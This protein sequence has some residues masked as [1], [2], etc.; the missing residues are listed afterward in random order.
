MKKAK[1][2]S[3]TRW[4][5]TELEVTCVGEKHEVWVSIQA[6]GPTIEMAY[7]ACLAN[8][9]NY[10]RLPENCTIS[11]YQHVLQRAELHWTSRHSLCD[12]GWVEGTAILLGFKSS[13][14]PMQKSK[15]RKALLAE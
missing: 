4:G 13:K 1:G 12:L 6:T 7:S 2:A 10:P 8:K 5:L 11:R 15:G 14:E 3:L 9:Q